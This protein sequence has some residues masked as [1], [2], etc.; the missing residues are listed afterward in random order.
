MVLFPLYTINGGV[1]ELKRAAKFGGDKIY[2]TY[3]EL[4]ESFSKKEVHP[5]D[6][7]QAVILALNKLLSPLREKFEDPKLIELVK[8]AYPVAEITAASSLSSP[9]SSQR[10]PEKLATAPDPSAKQG[11]SSAGEQTD[12]SRLD[13]RVGVIVKAEKHPNADSLYVEEIDVG[14]E[15][16]GTTRTIISGLVKFISLEDFIGKKVVVL[17]N[18]KPANMRGIKS[19]GMVLAASN[20]EYT[21]VEILEPPQD[22]VKGERIL[23]GEK[24]KG[25]PEEILNP[26]KQIFEKVKVDL[27]TDENCVAVFQDIPFLTSAG[28]CKVKSLVGASIS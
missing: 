9:P 22:A 5:G 4:E 24:H 11:S 20:A 17:C 12:L 16:A 10:N 28:P 6:L 23:F 26:K 3:E 14:D 21:K 25:T 7:K 19:N 27:K 13:L 15:P 8:K 1:F 2:A 18:L